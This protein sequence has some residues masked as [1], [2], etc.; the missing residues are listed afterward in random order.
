MTIAV[1]PATHDEQF[2]IRII[3]CIILQIEL[4]QISS[5]KHE[6][7]AS[8]LLGFM[9]TKKT[10]ATYETMEYNFH[11]YCLMFGV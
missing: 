9:A 1:A 4:Y 7:D 10:V 2:T 11:V 6:L 3:T 8:K 5:C